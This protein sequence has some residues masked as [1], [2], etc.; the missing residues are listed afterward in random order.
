MIDITTSTD[1][2]ELFISADPF[3]L[4]E[5]AEVRLAHAR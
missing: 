2:T 3:I 1:I 5:P 4:C